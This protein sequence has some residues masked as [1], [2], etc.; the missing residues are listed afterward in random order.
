M[1]T[2][3]K[4]VN[5]TKDEISNEMAHKAKV[6]KQKILARKMFAVLN[7]D[8]IYDNQTALNALS[9]YIKF[10]MAIRESKIKVNDL[11]LDLKKEPDT[12]ITQVM[13]ALKAE[14]QDEPAKDV[15]DLLERMGKTLEAFIARKFINN[16]MSDIKLEDIVA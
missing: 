3:K 2:P 11:L 6:E 13:E 7:A 1:P 12:K 8:S 14:L 16:P 15:A 4:R 9:G 10:E 5:K